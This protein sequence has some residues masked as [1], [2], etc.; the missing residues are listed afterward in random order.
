MINMGYPLD[1]TFKFFNISVG[2]LR[3]LV[4]VLFFKFGNL[5]F[6]AVEVSK[7]SVISFLLQNMKKFTKS[8]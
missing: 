1:L 2:S 3:D 8:I 6:L 5:T 7:E 4:F